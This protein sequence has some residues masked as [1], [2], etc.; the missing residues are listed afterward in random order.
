MAGVARHGWWP[1]GVQGRPTSLT[2]PP[3]AT[4]HVT[5]DGSLRFPRDSGH[6]YYLPF[7]SGG[8]INGQANLE[9]SAFSGPGLPID[10]D[11][12]PSP[13]CRI[14]LGIGSVMPGGF[15]ARQQGK[16]V[17]PCKLP[18]AIG[19]ENQAG[20]EEGR[21]LDLIE[22]SPSANSGPAAAVDICPGAADGGRALFSSYTVYSL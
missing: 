21:G 7:Q 9:K 1:A 3:A 6:Y 15:T 5:R 8:R 18:S 12:V 17:A 14:T 4:E 22:G 11:Q 13:L 19:G 10:R 20:V 16:R 2:R